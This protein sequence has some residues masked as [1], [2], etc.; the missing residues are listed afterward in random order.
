MIKRENA[1]ELVLTM[2]ASAVVSLLSMRLYL[3]IMNYPIVGKGYWHV[4]HALWGGV[5]MVVAMLMELSWQG[6]KNQRNAAIVFGLGFGL[7]VDEIGKYL[8]KD[9][10]Y[11]FQPAIL[12]IYLT[13]IGLFALYR[14]LQTLEPEEDKTKIYQSLGALEEAVE[15]DLSQ[16]EKEKALEKLEK[17][18]E[19]KVTMALRQM[20]K[21]LPIVEEKRN[22]EIDYVW[23]KIKGILV[24]FFHRKWVLVLLMGFT[25]Y[26]LLG[27]IADAMSITAHFKD[28]W[29]VE[30]LNDSASLDTR[31][32]LVLFKIKTV[33]DAVTSL[34]FGLGIY[35]VARDK[36]RYGA[37]VYQYGLIISIFITSF[38]RFYFEQFGGV[39]GLG[40]NI[41]LYYFLAY[42]RRK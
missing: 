38:F 39:I 21:S 6:K 4:A 30:M 26:F 18:K 31:S 36:R 29:L 27:T 13:F 16:K 11:F 35:W 24:R 22:E 34:F 9:S 12:F 23:R 10:N 33:I 19:T 20:I 32:E 41:L 17:I 25:I 40:I 7:F 37:K 14:Y 3:N 8:T 42:Y 5:A 1:S 28:N 15:G 2:M